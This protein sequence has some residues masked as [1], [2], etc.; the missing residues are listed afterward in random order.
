MTAR[1][2]LYRR[3]K[4]FPESLSTSP[5]IYNG[6]LFW[7]LLWIWVSKKLG[8]P[9]I[10]PRSPFTKI[11]CSDGPFQCRPPAKFEVRSFTR[12]WDNSGI[13]K[14]GQSLDT[15]TLPVL[16]NSGL[17]G[18]EIFHGTHVLGASRGHLC[19]SSAFLYFLSNATNKYWTTS[20]S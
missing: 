2:A 10:R 1:C 4:N 16:Q 5:E 20:N 8:S 7:L 18:L 19:D 13:Q 15:P 17:Q 12:S 9:W 14:F 6:L 3:P 11:F